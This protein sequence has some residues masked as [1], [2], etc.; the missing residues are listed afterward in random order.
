MPSTYSPLLRIQLITTGEQSGTWGAT[1]NTNFEDILEQ[2]I[3]G[4]AEINVTSG[5]VTLTEINGLED[6]SR[7]SALRV[8]GTPGVSRNIIAPA[9]SHNYVIAN[10]SNAVVVLKTS[11]STGLTIPVGQ[12]YLAYYD[13]VSLDFRMVGQAVASTNTANT[14]VLRDASGNFAAGVITAT[15]IT[16]TGNTTLGD[17]AGDTLT[18]NATPTFNV[19]V[20]ATSGG[21]GLTSYA[22]GDVIFASTSTALSKLAD[23]ATGNALLSGGVGVAP[24]YGK[25]GLTTHVSGTLPV[26]NGGTGVTSS[27]GTG[28]VVLSA[29]PTLT[30]TP[31][32]PTASPGTN[33]TQIATTAFVTNVAGSLGTISSQNSNNVAITGGTIDNVTTSGSTTSAVTALGYLGIPQNGKSAGYTLVLADAGKHVYYTGGAATLVVP[34]NASVAFP[35]GTTITII[36]NGSGALTISTTSITMNFAGTTSTGNRT[37]ATK[38]MATIIKVAT[39]GW[40]ISGVGLT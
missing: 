18:V 28:N 30:G 33:T 27:T 21:T 36:N 34:T 8:T 39:D 17:A 35:I 26:A 14:L 37:L 11:S 12:V 19:A 20:P 2:A 15:G 29:S 23:V 32:A 9:L 3:A 4:T 22:V 40:F 16:N 25:V 7:A 38:G 5:N 6:Q 13:P 1:T 10:G 31:I 24:A